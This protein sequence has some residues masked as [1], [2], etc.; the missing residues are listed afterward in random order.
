MLAVK[1][2]YDKVE[3]T[4]GQR[5]L[6]DRLWPR[7]IKS[8]DARIDKWMKELAP[9]DNLR[10]WFRHDPAKWAEFKRRYAAE[11]ASADSE[12]ALRELAA[13]A[14]QGNVTLVYGAR[15]REHNNAVALKEAVSRVMA[16]HGDRD[17]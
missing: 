16:A 11:L 5:I 4:D 12:R 3:A 1:R 8:E 6:V 10:K 2:A 14:G 7:G 9:S 13:A 15:D 17:V